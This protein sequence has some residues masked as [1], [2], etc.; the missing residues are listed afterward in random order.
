MADV[1]I[2]TSNG[3]MPAYV[4]TGWERPWPGMVVIHDFTRMSHDL[5]NQA[6]WLAVEGFLAAGPSVRST[7]RRS[8]RVLEC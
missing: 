1:M 2:A 8:N 3:Q 4:A 5:R 7:Y 6:G